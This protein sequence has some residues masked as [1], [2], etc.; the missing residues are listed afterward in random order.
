MNRAQTRPMQKVKM[1]RKSVEYLTRIKSC[2]RREFAKS[3][4]LAHF[5][6]KFFGIFRRVSEVANSDKGHATG[7]ECEEKCL[8]YIE[9][10]FVQVKDKKETA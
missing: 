6:K 3:T 4:N 7:E 5:V 9:T 1:C 8:N 2:K 10:W